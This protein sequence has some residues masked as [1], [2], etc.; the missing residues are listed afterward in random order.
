MM[1]RR[2]SALPR[3][4]HSSF[5]PT[6]LLYSSFSH[7]LPLSSLSPLLGLWDQD[8]FHNGHISTNFKPCF[9]F[10]QAIFT[11]AS[12]PSLPPLSLYRDRA[13]TLLALLLVKNFLRHHDLLTGRQSK[14][15]HS[16]RA[17][18]CWAQCARTR[19]TYMRVAWGSR[20]HAF[21]LVVDFRVA[22]SLGGGKGKPQ[23]N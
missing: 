3:S 2:R 9:F 4:L 8:S 19:A 17:R 13:S 18:H 22:P 23:K 5:S 15:E 16:T 7:F 21:I 20:I 11:D 6:P 12:V 10:F 1:I 14:D